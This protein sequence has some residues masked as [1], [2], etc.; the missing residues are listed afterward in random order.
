M[1]FAAVR[2]AKECVLSGLSRPR[3]YCFSVSRKAPSVLAKAS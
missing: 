2:E 3:I 1:H